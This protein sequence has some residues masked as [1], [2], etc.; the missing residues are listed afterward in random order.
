MRKISHKARRITHNGRTDTLAGWARTLG[1]SHGA[2]LWRIR[3]GWTEAEIVTLRNTCRSRNKGFR[4]RAIIVKQ[5][6]QTPALPCF[7]EMKRQHLAAQRQFNSLLRQFNRD[8][9]ALMGRGVGLD[10]F[11]NAND[12]TT[13][14]A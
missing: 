7:D 4:A 3:S 10:L 9:H 6:V 8:L 12:R 2:M 13:P 11:K 5:A 1:I 14:V